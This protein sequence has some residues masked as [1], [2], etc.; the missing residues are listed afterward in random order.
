MRYLV[1]AGD[2]YYPSGGMYD[3]KF[4]CN[5]IEEIREFLVKPRHDWTD[6]SWDW[7]HV[8]DLENPEAEAF[9]IEINSNL[10]I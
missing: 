8:F 1:F 10:Q 9:Q 4:R 3:L 5:T 6:D 7:H 2:Y